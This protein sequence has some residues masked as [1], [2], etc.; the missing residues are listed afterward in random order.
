MKKTRN[1][2]KNHQGFVL[3]STLWIVALISVAAMGFAVFNRLGLKSIANRT[4]VSQLEEVASGIVEAVALQIV[5]E[6]DQAKPGRKRNGEF[7]TCSASNQIQAFISVQD[8]NGLIDLNSASSNLLTGL[9]GKLG[10]QGLRQ[11]QLVASLLDFKDADDFQRANGAEK[12]AYVSS[13]LD[14]SP[15]NALFE[16]VEELDQILYFDPEIV[17]RLSALTT[18]YSRRDGFDPS[19]APRSLKKLFEDKRRQGRTNLFT[20]GPGKFYSIVVVAKSKSKVWFERKAM[21]SVTGTGEKPFSIVR[22]NVVSE[23][24]EKQRLN[25]MGMQTRPCWFN[26]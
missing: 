1:D 12:K 5:L 9:F 8:Q 7:F 6:N 14:Y 17:R 3:V 18:V 19:L 11:Q 24:T 10:F 15:K 4:H 20:S 26:Q 13:G 25:A 22:W 23:I 16:S 2:Q 21:I